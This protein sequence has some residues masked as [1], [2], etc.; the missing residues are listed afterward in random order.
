VLY[1]LLTGERLFRGS[2]AADTLAQLLTKEP[3][4]DRVP[5]QVRRLL[6]R[7]L[8]KDPKHRLRD[9]GDVRD[10]LTDA[11]PSRKPVRGSSLGWIAAGVVAIVLGAALWR[12]TH[13]GD[14]PLKPL[15]RLDVDL[16][17]DALL[18]SPLGADVA[19]SP[20]GTRLVYVSQ[21]RLFTRRL[22]QPKSTE[23]AGTQ[24]AFAVFF[25]PDGES[26]AF[27]ANSQLKRISVDGGAPITVCDA[28]TPRGGSWGEDGN[29][30][31]ALNAPAVLSRVNS[32]GGKPTPV[33][34]L[35]RGELN[36]RWPQILPGG[37]AVLF[38]AG[39]ALN[40]F[41]DATIDVMS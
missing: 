22:D 6:R 40:G 41:D 25:S 1:E 31:A 17:P 12:A 33:T 29:I 7:C 13:S 18:N 24:G 10:L 21:G 30:I 34:E 37:K 36:H 16:G 5:P 26:V 19:I 28:P 20:D 8:E 39:R 9:I 14:S 4:M 35:A 3:P 32:T 27:F 11:E 2:E 23:L 15:M 38:T